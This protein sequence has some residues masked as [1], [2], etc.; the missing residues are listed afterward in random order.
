MEKQQHRRLWLKFDRVLSDDLLKQFLLLAGLFCVLLVISYA[1]LSLSAPQWHQFCHDRNLKEWLLPIYLLIDTNALNSLYIDNGVHGWMLFASSITYLAGLFVFNGMIIS[2]MNNALSNRIDRHNNGLIHYLRSGHY[3]IMGY[4]DM[5]PSIINHIFARNEDA[6]VLLLTS[7]NSVKIKERLR[8][9]LGEEKLRR[10]IINYGHRM[11]KDGYRDIRLESAREIFIV[12]YRALPAHDAIN[13]ECVDSI[14]SYLSEVRPKDPPKRITCVF[15][16]LDTYAAFKTTEIFGAVREL[17]IE[18]V[19]YNFYAGWAKQLF[20]L[21]RHSSRSTLQSDTAYPAVYGHGITDK[22]DSQV[23]LV[24]V[25]TTNFAVAFAIEAAHVL[26]FPN[27][28]SRSRE[29]QAKTRTKITFIDRNAD[30]ERHIFETRNRHLFDVQS[31]RY[32]D[33][34]ET[35]E[36]SAQASADEKPDF[37]D[38]EF[39]FIKGDVFSETIRRQLSNWAKDESQHLSIFLAMADQ[40]NNFAIGMN[41]PDEVYDRC[42]PIFIRQ[43][44]SDNFVTNLREADLSKQLTY[45]AWDETSGKVKTEKRNGR[46]AHIFPFGMNDTGYSSDETS[47]R[48]AKLINYLYHN[49]DYS[50]N[51]FPDPLQLSTIPLKT[52]WEDADKAWGNLTV[53]NK[54]SNLYCAYSLSCKL[55]SLRAMR[56]LAPDDTSRDL[57]PMSDSE[58]EVM[59]KVEHNRWNVEKLLMGFRRARPEED[60]YRHKESADELKRNKSLFIHYDIRPYDDLD[61]ETK[62]LDIQLTKYIPW[63][64]K[65]TENDI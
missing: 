60:K 35:D 39:E 5:C 16:D 52:L 21:Q 27:F 42:I 4:D 49:A 11:S 57:E 50:T 33:L 26:H 63:V 44:R 2:V 10:I 48:R 31:L 45:A 59:A 15:E 25:G 6:Y 56:G 41:M 24:F 53:A 37:L 51:T 43:D 61:E 29:S 64:L 7:A 54:W 23:H 38:I 55:S 40:R 8:R 62:Q 19:P 30:K 13:I 36:S 28:D 12:G 46:Y 9:S 22:D 65:M 18:F 1:L 3:I 14:C 47:L 20:V 58:T 17:G 34:S 32:R